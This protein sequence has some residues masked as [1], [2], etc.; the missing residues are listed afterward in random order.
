M[1]HCR[2][3]WARAFYPLALA[4]LASAQ[5]APIQPGQLP[6]SAQT[7][8]SSGITAEWDVRANM[9]Q[10]SSAIEQFGPIL[11][12]LRPEEWI[13]K[14]ASGSY[15]QQVRSSREMMTALTDAT[16]KLAREPERLTAAL[17]AYFLMERMELLLG[18]LKDGIRRYQSGTTADDLNGGR[19]GSQQP[20]RQTAPA[21]PRSGRCPRTG[22]QGRG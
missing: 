19:R 13:A 7:Q 18:S 5:Q 12:R 10:L 20:S 14:G 17:D 3:M 6:K 1:R 9:E 2:L 11:R 16:A 22:F 15:V 21:H 8:P 4:A